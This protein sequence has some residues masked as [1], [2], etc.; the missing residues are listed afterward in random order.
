M[1]FTNNSDRVGTYLVL[2][3]LPNCA[4][5]PIFVDLVF[6]NFQFSFGDTSDIGGD[7]FLWAKGRY[8]LI[9]RC[10]TDIDWNSELDTLL[11]NEQ[12][13]R[14]L[15]I[16]SP[17]IDMYIP[18][19]LISNSH[20]PWPKNPPRDLLRKK[21]IA[22]NKYKSHRVSFGRNHDLTTL[23]WTE[24][25]DR[26]SEIKNFAIKSQKDYELKL[27]SQIGV[28]PKLFHSYINH[29]KVARSVVGP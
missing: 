2:P 18:K 7:Y 28:N 5:C 29:R 6:Q 10:L 11:P 1:F 21:S 8:D 17:M 19:R 15:N 24:F 3:P 9:S 16:L 20:T 12:F 27:S 13:N 25:R 22:W 26:N 23:A 4:H 14:L